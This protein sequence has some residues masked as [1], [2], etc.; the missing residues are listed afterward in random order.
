MEILLTLISAWTVYGVCQ[1]DIAM[2]LVATVLI[3]FS[4]LKQSKTAAASTPPTTR[5]INWINPISL[6]ILLGWFW[7]NFIPENRAD[8]APIG[9]AQSAMVFLS[10]F[11]W[12]RFDYFYRTY[13]LRF[14][15]WLIVAL[16]INVKFDQLAY[17]VFWIFCFLNSWFIFVRGLMFFPD[18]KRFADKI[19]LKKFFVSLSYFA[20]MSVVVTGIFLSLLKFVKFSDRAFTIFLQEYF[21][22]TPQQLLD[23]GS[24][25]DLRGPGYVGREVRPILE[26]D[27]NG[28]DQLYLATQVFERYEDG[29]WRKPQNLPMRPFPNTLDHAKKR[30]DLILFDQLKGII[31]TPAHVTAASNKDQ[32]FE[33]DVEGIL[34]SPD[35]MTLKATFAVDENII[36]IF[37]ITERR[38]EYLTE[39]CSVLQEKL[40]PYLEKIVEKDAS[41]YKTAW[42]IEKYFHDNFE[43]T[44]NVRFGAGELGI[45]SML[46]EKKPAYCSYFATAMVLLLRARNIPARLKTGFFASELIDNDQKFLVRMRDAHAWVE[47]LLP[48]EEKPGFYHWMDFD[49]TP[50]ISRLEILQMGRSLSPFVDW[51]WR[52]QRRVRSELVSMD[53]TQL[54][55]N[56]MMVALIFIVVKNFKDIFYGFKT[57]NL[58][59]RRSKR[60]ENKK[61]EICI[62]VYQA[63]EEILQKAFRIKRGDTQTDEELIRQMREEQLASPEMIRSIESFLDQYHAVRFGKKIDQHIEDRLKTI[64]SEIL[65][66]ISS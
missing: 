58:F 11:I 44:L 8:F 32:I 42:A 37:Q 20:M 62:R 19:K 38:K 23:F 55:T 33:Q 6:A 14:L 17:I 40:E 43:Y 3:V 22:V 39:I 24:T 25:L 61:K 2:P 10:L 16:S 30:I 45:L 66:S 28:K 41:P 5:K 59:R 26:I 52:S 31:P 21:F 50:A 9:I 56:I 49:P 15:A 63:F 7:R 13:A 47:A 35:P 34:S 12:F 60:I 46:E 36:P 1:K 29:K 64:K 65:K 51:L 57:F 18:E 48:V 53:S 54:V 27:R 4:F